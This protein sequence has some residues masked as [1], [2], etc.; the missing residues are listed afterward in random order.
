MRSLEAWVTLG[1]APGKRVFTTGLGW[2]GAPGCAR[3]RPLQSQGV[4]IP[5][6]SLDLGLRVMVP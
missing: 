3:T 1:R 6:T 4:G 5:G 2:E